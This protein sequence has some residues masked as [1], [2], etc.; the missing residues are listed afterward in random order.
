MPQH[1]DFIWRHQFSPQGSPVLLSV[2]VGPTSPTQSQGALVQTFLELFC[3]AF[4]PQG[5]GAGPVTTFTAALLII[6]TLSIPPF[7]ASGLQS[8]ESHKNR[9][10]ELQN[11]IS[12]INQLECLWCLTFTFKKTEDYKTSKPHIK[13]ADTTAVGPKVLSLALPRSVGISSCPWDSLNIV[14]Q[15]HW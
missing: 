3:T 1:R 12:H 10:N 11:Q 6:L 9:R 4:G 8:Q 5:K 2:G 7:H 14:L 15:T 13:Q